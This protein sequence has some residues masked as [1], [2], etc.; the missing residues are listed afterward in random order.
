METII[1]EI[2]EGIKTII[3][4]IGVLFIGLLLINYGRC[5]QKQE[6]KLIKFSNPTVQEYCKDAFDL[7]C[8]QVNT[9]IKQYIR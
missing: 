1:Y 8:D 4:V 7:T 9:V 2:V 3:I 6:D 5:L